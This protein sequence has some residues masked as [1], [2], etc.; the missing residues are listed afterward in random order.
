M[1]PLIYYS[2]S[3]CIYDSPT[4]DR[5]KAVIQKVFPTHEIVDPGTYDDNEE[6]DARGMEY[7]FELVEKCDQFVF[8]RCLGEVTADGADQRIKSIQGNWGS[9][10]EIV[11]TKAV[12]ND[13]LIVS[14]TPFGPGCLVVCSPVGPNWLPLVA[15]VF[16][17]IVINAGVFRLWRTG[18]ESKTDT[19]TSTSSPGSAIFL[20]WGI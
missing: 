13:L 6:K 15:F 11:Y 2:H 12:S 17:L 1:T 8:S 5:E 20:P 14:Y 7:C 10:V 9:G 19:L 3:M 18:R 16:L 4:E